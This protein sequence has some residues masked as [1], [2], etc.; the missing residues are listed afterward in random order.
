MGCGLH[1]HAGLFAII[2]RRDGR[3]SKRRRQKGNVPASSLLSF[4]DEEEEPAS[5]ASQPFRKRS[6]ASAEAAVSFTRPAAR[7]TESEALN[8]T[9]E[10][11]SAEAVFVESDSRVEV[12]VDRAAPDVVAPAHDEAIAD[13]D[14]KK[15]MT[16]K[17]PIEPEPKDPAPM[18]TPAAS[19][20][21]RHGDEGGPMAAPVRFLVAGDAR[22]Q[23]RRL[24]V[25]AQKYQAKAGPFAALLCVGDFFGPQV[26]GEDNTCELQPYLTGKAR[27]PIPTY[28]ICGREGGAGADL[29][30]SMLLQA[31]QKMATKNAGKDEAKD[32]K[33][34]VESSVPIRLCENLHFLG[35]RGVAHVSGLRVA[36]LSG[37]FS[38]DDFLSSPRETEGGAYC[39]NY[40]E[41]QLD[42]L[43][44]LIEA[45]GSGHEDC[46]PKLGGSGRKGR[47]V[48]V[49]L[50][51]E[52]P[53]L[54]PD[55]APLPTDL[56]EPL[57]SDEQALT[58]L[59]CP[60]VAA[61]MGG[62]DARYHFAGTQGVYYAMKPYKNTVHSTR[63]YAMGWVNGAKKNKSIK[64][65][66][67]VP[68]G[69]MSKR[70]LRDL[71]SA[72]DANPFVPSK[73]PVNVQA[74]DGQAETPSSEPRQVGPAVG[75]KADIKGNASVFHNGLC[76]THTVF[77]DGRWEC[78]FCGN[79]NFARQNKQ[80]N[81]RKCMA[82]APPCVRPAVGVAPKP[83]RGEESV[84]NGAVKTAVK[85][86][87][88]S[89]KESI[90]ASQRPR[91]RRGP[92]NE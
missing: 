49:I 41:D 6:R 1:A 73:D 82:P 46:G 35:R 59:G 34:K 28:F 15:Y 72:A 13:D 18:P 19:D 36:F 23:F 83:K 74:K 58:H 22:G 31:A 21:D 78:A 60:G 89:K 33:S 40:C 45:Q 38:I 70:S 75:S 51:A 79:V 5:S 63:F 88:R 32:A 65:F 47:G 62:I 14:Y 85:T 37:C 20:G 53:R 11:Q 12:P 57:A 68:V 29:I 3:P 71:R 2:M 48:D 76:K 26:A 54:N 39:A 80:C 27:V 4:G 24:F 9:A 55:A 30:G 10:A 8:G 86:G 69:K 66:A 92:R 61:L 84:E 91:K 16:Y 90:Y 50:T 64:A 7:M 42:D 87:K 56:P 43:V 44:D 67:V 25:T 52:W 81:I 17:A 77:P